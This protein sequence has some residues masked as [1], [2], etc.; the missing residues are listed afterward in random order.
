MYEK[1]ARVTYI[2]FRDDE[3][4]TAILN[5]ILDSAVVF[6]KDTV[7]LKEIAGLRKKNPIHKIARIA[8]LPFMLVGSIF[9][10]QGI[11]NLYSNPESDGGTKLLLFGA[12]LFAVGFIPYQLNMADLTVGFGGEWTI[13]IYKGGSFPQ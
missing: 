7:Q 9:M 13:Q 11:A 2:K 5:A 1:N 12:G 3:Y 8:G 6:G 4:T 10:G